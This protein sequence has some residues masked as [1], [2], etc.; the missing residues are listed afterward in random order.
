[1]LRALVCLHSN[2]AADRWNINDKGHVL[3]ASQTIQVPTRLHYATL[4]LKM[5]FSSRR[6][7]SGRGFSKTYP[8]T[9]ELTC[10]IAER[11]QFISLGPSRI[12]QFSKFSRQATTTLLARTS[13]GSFS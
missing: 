4:G 13:P 1:A 7:K 11:S 8:R 9:A 5:C 6:M 2:T 3:T 10:Q 12:P